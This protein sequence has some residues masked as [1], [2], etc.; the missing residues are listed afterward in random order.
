MHEFLEAARKF[1]SRA[2]QGHD[3]AAPAVGIV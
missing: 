3:R 1:A 2:H